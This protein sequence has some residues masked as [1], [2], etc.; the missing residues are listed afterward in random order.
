MTSTAVFGF[1][2]PSQFQENGNEIANTGAGTP[3]LGKYEE[4]Q[5]YFFFFLD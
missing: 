3:L 1:A 4:T 5:S 2:L